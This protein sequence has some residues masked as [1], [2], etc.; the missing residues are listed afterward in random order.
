L[1]NGKIFE[2]ILKLNE[3]ILGQVVRFETQID[4]TSFLSA[5]LVKIKA[6]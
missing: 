2:T 1:E 4:E 3:K 5:T 6:K